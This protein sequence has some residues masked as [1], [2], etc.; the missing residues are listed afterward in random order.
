MTHA[1]VPDNIKEE[2]GINKGLIRLS[3]GIENAND[4]IDDLKQALKD[5]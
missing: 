4:I 2:I 5:I 3:V 1:D